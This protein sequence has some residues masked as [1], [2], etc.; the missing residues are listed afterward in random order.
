MS[1]HALDHQHIE[2]MSFLTFSVDHPP[3]SHTAQSARSSI[4]DASTT[5]AA[6]EKVT[7]ATADI[8]GEHNGEAGDVAR[9]QTRSAVYGAGVDDRGTVKGKWRKGEDCDLMR[10]DSSKRRRS[11]GW[12]K[13]LASSFQTNQPSFASEDLLEGVPSLLHEVAEHDDSGGDN[14]KRWLSSTAPATVSLATNST[15]RPQLEGYGVWSGDAPPPKHRGA[16]LGMVGTT[17][18]RTDAGFLEFVA[19]SARRAAHEPHEVDAVVTHAGNGG[20]DTQREAEGETSDYE[21]G[22]ST[23]EGFGSDDAG[24]LWEGGRRSTLMGPLGRTSFMPNDEGTGGEIEMKDSTGVGTGGEGN[25]DNV[26]STPRAAGEQADGGETTPGATADEMETGGVGA[27]I[28]EDATIESG[29]TVPTLDADS[30]VTATTALE[31]D[32]TPNSSKGVK[33]GENDD[34]ADKESNVG[35]DGR[36]MNECSTAPA[37]CAEGAKVGDISTPVA[38][39]KSSYFGSISP[40]PAPPSILPYTSPE[41]DKKEGGKEG[42]PLPP[43]AVEQHTPSPSAK[44]GSSPAIS[45]GSSPKE[46][47]RA[48]RLSW[49]ARASERHP[50]P[51]PVGNG[52]NEEPDGGTGTSFAAALDAAAAGGDQVAAAALPAGGEFAPSFNAGDAPAVVDG[53]DK[54]ASAE[55]TDG[56]SA[57]GVT[58]GVDVERRARRRAMWR[59]REK[60]WLSKDQLIDTQVRPLEAASEYLDVVGLAQ[61]GAVCRAWRGPLSGEEGRRQWMR[62]VRLPDGVPDMWRAKFYLHILYDQPS[63]VQQVK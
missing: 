56:A 10:S 59:R 50:P 11:S 20:A 36:D 28:E 47:P 46:S 42:D 6:S 22:S 23:T 34:H 48:W 29:L 30:F 1:N 9:G 49:W 3:R 2:R 24:D 61:S 44:V 16:D 17:A 4:A 19:E 57:A 53:G 45:D 41:T 63:W 26:A 15:G 14:K 27:L 39:P 25:G 33:H 51:A 21:T 40:S 32:S 8:E 35:Q 37:N 5:P 18:S 38:K 13:R 60:P 7:S 12:F 43:V 54:T 52:E 58:A 62:C 31:A 55:K